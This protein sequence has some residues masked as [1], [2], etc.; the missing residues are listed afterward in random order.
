MSRVSAVAAVLN[1]LS[2]DPCLISSG[3]AAKLTAPTAPP[4]D[5][6]PPPRIPC[7]PQKR[8][9]EQGCTDQEK[10]ESGPYPSTGVRAPDAPPADLG[11]AD[12][13]KRGADDATAG[14]DDFSRTAQKA[15]DQAEAEAADRNA[16]TN[17]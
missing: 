2:V 17:T 5:Y 6:P 7:C 14:P 8:I 12:L 3:A 15:M 4:T 16:H 1:A 13:S 10:A 9:Q 11:Q